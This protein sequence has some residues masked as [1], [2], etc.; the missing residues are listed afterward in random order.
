M[1]NRLVDRQYGATGG[2]FFLV[3]S[4]SAILPT[5]KPAE[6]N[7]PAKPITVI[8]SI[9]VIAEPSFLQ[10]LRRVSM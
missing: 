4:L 10:I 7:S 5:A 3:E 8:N 9:T 1:L 6:K 2:H